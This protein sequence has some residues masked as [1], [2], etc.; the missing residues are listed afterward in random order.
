MPP[1]EFLQREL[2][3]E[4]VARWVIFPIQNLRARQFRPGCL[5][6]LHKYSDSGIEHS[7]PEPL[8]HHSKYKSLATSRLDSRAENSNR[9]GRALFLVSNFH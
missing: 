8:V 2:Q 7:L 6:S 9:Q 3:A 5:N 4:T 1:D